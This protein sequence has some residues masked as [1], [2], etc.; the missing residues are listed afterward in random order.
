MLA[1]RSSIFDRSARG[2]DAGARGPRHLRRLLTGL[3]V[4][5]CALAL[6][7]SAF[8]EGSADMNTGP[9]TAFRQALLMPV[10]APGYLG[11]QPYTVL[12]AYAQAGETIQLGSSATA[13]SSNILVYAPGTNLEGLA[14]P[15]DPAFATDIFDCDTDDPGTGVIATRAQELAG[16]QPNVG[17][18]AP[19]EFVAATSGLYPIIMFP[20]DPAVGG[21]GGAT[22]DAP[23]QSAG[24]SIAMWDVTVRDAG[25]V[26]RPGRVYSS[27]FSLAT[28]STNA[29]GAE[30]FPY[31]RTGYEYKVNFF[32]QG[33]VNWILRSDDMGV[34]D[35]A[36]GDRT[37]ASF[38]CGNDQPGNNTC[39]FNNATLAPQ[40]RSY[41]LF[42]N[43][44]DPLVISGPGGLG[45][46]RGFATAPISPASTPIAN[47]AFTGSGGQAGATNRGSGGTIAFTAPTQMQGLDYTVAID[48]NKD[49]TFGNG[50]DYVDDSGDLSASGSNAYAWNGRDAAGNVPA[51]GDYQYQIRSSL[52]QVHFALTDVENSGGTQIQRLSLPSDPALGDPLAANYDNRDPYKSGYVVTDN[53][54]SFADDATSGPGF[55]SWSANSGN[56]DYIDTWAKLPEVGTTGTLRLACAD[57]QVTK[58]GETSQM[59]PGKSFTYHVAVKNNG[60]DAATNV[61]A[62]DVLPKPLTFASASSGCANANGTVTCTLA[63]L[64]SGSTHTFEITVKVPSSLKKCVDNKATVANDTPDPNLANNESTVCVPLLPEADLSIKKVASDATVPPGGQIMYTLVVKNDG[65]SDAE[66]VK[67]T[68]PM[69]S[70]LSL[71]S[72]KPSQGTCST[73]GGKVACSIGDLEAGG[74]AQVLVTATVTAPMGSCG[75]SAIKN[76]GTVTSDSADKDQTNNK[77]STSI[78][79]TPDPQPKFDL[80]VTKT[81]DDKSVYVGQPLKYTVTVTNKGPD[82]A[83][84][85]KITDT[86][87]HPA[88]VVSVK[89]TQGKCS[90]TIPMTC[91]LGTIKVGGNVTITVTVKLRESGCKQRNAASATGAGADT[92]PA[93]NLARVDVCATRVPLRLT[94]VAD[95]ASVRAGGTVSY[96]I[97]VWNPTAGEAKEVQ[98]CDKLPSGLVYVSSK[99]RARYTKGQYCWTIETLAAHKSRNYRITVR[100]LG[101][102]SGDRVNRATASAPGAQ[103]KHAKYPV[104]VLPA[105]ASGGGVTG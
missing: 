16:P 57:V 40:A 28:S 48:T 52:A 21:G 105:R 9:G 73:A 38:A 19:C 64:A 45:Q 13:G 49:G 77:A 67:V 55:N 43:Q 60:P 75:A 71:V 18:Y 94:K 35:A 74:S 37:F 30:V 17:G 91:Q 15:T 33:G 100:A 24:N 72:A 26:A 84:D 97:R 78:C 58:T 95:N 7:A 70:G 98:V 3:L 66:G 10:P 1:A 5:L 47:A 56:T 104:H 36:T 85:A 96:T 54:T 53:P 69:A 44:V 4:G 42:V 20:P 59:V 102:A 62:T 79:T 14:F 22:V 27:N 25:A 81:V 101:S 11:L 32:D 63:S 31:T 87:N 23:A 89:S 88:S 29:S 83:S 6:P 34:V 8:G 68:D 93:N 99:A 50:T 39:Q 46:T 103:T 82:A 2:P 76:T 65:P 90:K 86:L 12:Y 92:N 41:P 61:K 51:C 80:A